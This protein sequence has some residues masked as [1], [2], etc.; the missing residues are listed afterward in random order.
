M[1][2][3]GKFYTKIVWP[4]CLCKKAVQENRELFW[5]KLSAFFETIL[6]AAGDF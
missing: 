1:Q 5:R 3:G 4:D 2:K 6:L